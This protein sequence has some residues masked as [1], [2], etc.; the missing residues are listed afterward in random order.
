MTFNYG[1]GMALGIFYAVLVVNLI[2]LYGLFYWAVKFHPGEAEISYNQEQHPA[3]KPALLFTY[4]L[5]AVYYIL[6]MLM[7][8]QNLKRIKSI[9]NSRFIVFCFTQMVHIIFIMGLLLGVYSRQFENG[10]AQVFF[11]SLCNLYM[12]GLAYITYPTEVYFKEYRIDEN[13]QSLGN[14]DV[15]RAEVP[16]AD[17]SSHNE[18]E[19]S[20]MKDP[21]P[22]EEGIRMSNAK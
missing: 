16:K 15:T 22:L 12:F 14:E 17:I 7:L 4:L 3:L 5:L 2:T 18:I 9:D 6:Y 19:L 11:Y 20:N 10:G 8:C 13:L 1:I 21:R